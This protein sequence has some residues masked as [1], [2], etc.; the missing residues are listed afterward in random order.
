VHFI[1][2]PKKKF[3]QNKFR[4]KILFKSAKIAL[5]LVYLVIL[6]VFVRLTG[7]GMVVHWPKCFGYYIPQ[8]KELLLLQH[9]KEY[10]KVK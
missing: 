1:S 7:S 9:K 2:T 8:Q 3:Y 4:V 6:P 10:D 5:V